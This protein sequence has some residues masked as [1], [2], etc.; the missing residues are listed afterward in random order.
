MAEE[1]RER[2]GVDALLDQFQRKIDRLKESSDR[3]VRDLVE[4]VEYFGKSPRGRAQTK[5]F[6]FYKHLLRGGTIA[7][8]SGSEGMS[9]TR[10]TDDD[11]P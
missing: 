8:I 10:R 2:T 11:Q 1:F 6:L 7:E 9:F 4:M 3:D 5:E